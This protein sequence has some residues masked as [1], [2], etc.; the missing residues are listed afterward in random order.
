MR[1]EIDS[2]KKSYYQLVG[3]VE[4]E[5]ASESPSEKNQYKE[6]YEQTHRELEEYKKK[7]YRESFDTETF[8][9]NIRKEGEGND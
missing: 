6:L 1:I 4:G 9:I 2:L 7:N 8:Q 5:T 3:R